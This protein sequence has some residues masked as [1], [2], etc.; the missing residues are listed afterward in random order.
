LIHYT[1]HKPGDASSHAQSL[2]RFRMGHQVRIEMNWIGPLA[3]ELYIADADG[4]RSWDVRSFFNISSQLHSS[5]KDRPDLSAERYRRPLLAEASSPLEPIGDL[6]DSEIV[7]MSTNDLDADRQPF[8][9]S[10]M[11][12]TAL[13]A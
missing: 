5:I 12:Y 8:C 6:K 1:I 9:R 7:A 3:S 11:N 4:T 10:W 2:H 13:L